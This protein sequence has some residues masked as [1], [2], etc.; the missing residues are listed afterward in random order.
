MMDDTSSYMDQ[1][2]SVI[3]K[4][5]APCVILASVHTH[6][7]SRTSRQSHTYDTRKSALSTHTSFDI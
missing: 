4:G 5:E 2:Q 1:N 6:H 7:S 3:R